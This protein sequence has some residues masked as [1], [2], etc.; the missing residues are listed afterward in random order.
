[1][2][3]IIGLDRADGAALRAK[4]RQEHLDFVRAAARVKLGGPFLDEA[5]RMVGSMMIVDGE[6]SEDVAAF[7]AADP[8]R[9]AGLFDSVEVR[10]WKQTVGS[11]QVSS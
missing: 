6:N 3:V 10:E 1:L 8:Y 5:G 9:T 7:A 4:V 2:Y 11:A